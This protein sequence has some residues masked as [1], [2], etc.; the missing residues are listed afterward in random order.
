MC[1]KCQI[2]QCHK[3]KIQYF[4]LALKYVWISLFS[5]FPYVRLDL[6]DLLRANYYYT[7]KRVILSICSLRV[8]IWKQSLDVLYVRAVGQ[9]EATSNS[10]SLIPLT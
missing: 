4:T 5:N 6:L 9:S 10:V 1:H 2:C 8:I 7:N 3:Y